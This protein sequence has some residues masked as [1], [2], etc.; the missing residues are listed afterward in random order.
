MLPPNLWQK[1]CPGPCWGE[2]RTGRLLL[3]A[4]AAAANV[5]SSATDPSTPG[6]PLPL[7]AGTEQPGGCL[8][9]SPLWR[10]SVVIREH[11][12]VAPR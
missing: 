4:A 1:T 11:H 12:C 10:A 2:R 3:G 9:A 5:R 6:V 8:Y 7:L